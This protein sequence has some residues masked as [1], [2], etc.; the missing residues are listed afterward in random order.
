MMF[1]NSVAPTCFSPLQS[2]IST[3]IEAMKLRRSIWKLLSSS[4]LNSRGTRLGGGRVSQHQIITVR[5]PTDAKTSDGP[6]MKHL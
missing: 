6:R 5:G 2:S 3:P 1:T 4:R